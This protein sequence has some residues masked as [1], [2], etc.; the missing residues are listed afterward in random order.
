MHEERIE[1]RRG[2]DGELLGW[3]EPRGDGFV[4]VDLLG[5]ERT[6]VVDWLAAEEEL[7]QLGLSYLADLYELRL[8]DGEW[9]RVR[10]AEVRPS[11]VRV[12]KDDWGAVGAP[13]VYYELP[14][15]VAEEE[16]RPLRR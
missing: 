15:P 16:L 10:I 5:R 8:K 4:A 12:K 13:Q 2:D 11:L 6:G 14:L 9:L 1:Q 7:E 3:I